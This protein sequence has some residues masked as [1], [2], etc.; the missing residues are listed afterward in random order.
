[1]PHL[2]GRPVSFL[3]AP[4]GVDK[5]M[6]FQKHMT[7]GT[8][9]GV[10]ELPQRLDPDHEPLMEVA[11]DQGLLSAAQM[12]VVEFHTWNAVKTAMVRPGRMVCDLDPGKGASWSAMQEA[13]L[14]IQALL[15]EL[16]LVPFVKT[17]GGK[18]LHIVVPLQRRHDWDTVK[19]FSHQVVQHLAGTFP[20]RFASKSGPRNRIGKIFIDYLRNGFGATTVCAWSARARPGMAVSVPIKWSEVETLKGSDHWHIGN[21]HERLDVGNDP[22]KVYDKSARTLTVGRRMLKALQ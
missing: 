13:A 10:R 11:R 12:N 16:E 6:F 22:W 4:K 7:A 5:K 19:D 3:R 9:K 21:I 15:H 14:L 17:S 2:A 1:M 8:M 18:G 20:K